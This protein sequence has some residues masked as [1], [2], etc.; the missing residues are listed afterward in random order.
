MKSWKSLVE[1]LHM[2]K[3]E[4]SKFEI[5][6]SFKDH[7]KSWSIRVPPKWWFIWHDTGSLVSKRDNVQGVSCDR[8]LGRTH[9]ARPDLGPHAHVC[10]PPIWRGRTS[11]PHPHTYGKSNIFQLYFDNFSAIFQHF[12]M[13]LNKM[14]VLKQERMFLNGIRCSRIDNFMTVLF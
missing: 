8:F 2:Y 14:E 6:R 12:Q 3:F 9:L 13:F 4:V 7:K 1:L 10:A 5:T 11:H